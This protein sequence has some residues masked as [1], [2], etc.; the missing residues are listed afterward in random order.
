LATSI[1]TL[2]MTDQQIAQK[3]ILTAEKNGL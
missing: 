3:L 1:S 2:Q